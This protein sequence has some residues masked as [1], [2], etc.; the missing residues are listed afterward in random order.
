LLISTNFQRICYAFSNLV[1]LYYHRPS[2]TI[3][4]NPVTARETTIILLAGYSVGGGKTLRDVF[5]ILDHQRALHQK[6]LLDSKEGGIVR[7]G[8]ELAMIQGVNV[9]FAHP[10]KVES[11][12][13]EF[14]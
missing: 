4:G 9:L 10:V 11:L 13:H 8:C 5:D 2:L 3:E 14:L 12:A 1:T 7:S 6:V